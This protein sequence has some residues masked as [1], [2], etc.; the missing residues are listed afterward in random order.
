[1]G[2]ALGSND[3]SVMQ[4]SAKNLSVHLQGILHKGILQ[5]EQ[6]DAS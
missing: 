1:M 6:Y 2:K 3:D 4:V 5:G